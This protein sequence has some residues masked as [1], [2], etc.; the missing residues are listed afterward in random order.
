MKQSD[1][2]HEPNH[3]FG[4]V[5][6]QIGHKAVSSSGRKSGVIRNANALRS[7]NRGGA[8]SSTADC[9]QC[10]IQSLVSISA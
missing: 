3:E 6:S 8:H 1:L 5:R 10:T 4:L 9:C 2:G 7:R